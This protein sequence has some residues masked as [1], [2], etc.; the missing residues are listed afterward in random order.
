MLQP[1]IQR[2]WNAYT[3]LVNWGL[4]NRPIY[5]DLGSG[6][7]I[8]LDS[9]ITIGLFT[10]IF[11]NQIYQPAFSSL[12]GIKY[13]VDLGANRGLFML[14]ACHELRNNGNEDFSILCIEPVQENLAWLAK[15]VSR[16]HLDEKV[17]T[18][19]GAVHEKRSGTIDLFYYP[20]SHVTG[21]VNEKKNRRNQQVPIIDLF[22]FLE[23]KEIDI[24]KIDIEGSEEA[25]LRGNAE[26]LPLT[27]VLIIEFH[28][29]RIDYA[30][31][32][33][34]IEMAGLN[35]IQE[36]S[37]QPDRTVVEVYSRV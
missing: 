19:R 29:D 9:T 5:V 30:S 7:S 1:I 4:K 25:F 11:V 27:N 8:C 34:R 32:R 20:G 21:S 17:Y 26:I 28:L 13:I 6:Y 24:L 18:V 36:C 10:E 31:C 35:F 37:R 22:G 23:E 33:K 12:K 2:Y 15:A 16:N 3:R 14:Y